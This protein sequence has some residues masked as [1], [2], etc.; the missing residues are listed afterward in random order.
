MDSRFQS[1]ISTLTFDLVH[2]CILLNLQLRCFGLCEALIALINSVTLD[3][4]NMWDFVVGEGI[5]IV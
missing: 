4:F 1:M 3:K 2:H 5:T